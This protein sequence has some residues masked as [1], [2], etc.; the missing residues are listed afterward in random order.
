MREKGER[1]L[2]RGAH[3]WKV[4]NK[5]RMDSIWEG[6]KGGKRNRNDII[7]ISKIKIYKHYISF[8]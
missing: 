1:E 8:Q 3:D 7:I 5:G 4:G 6:L 2:K